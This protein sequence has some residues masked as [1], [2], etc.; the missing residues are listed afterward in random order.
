M[1]VAFPLL[2]S[3]DRLLQQPDHR[4]SGG[5][6]AQGHLLR[7]G[8]SL[9]ERGKGHGRGFPP[10]AQREAGQTRPLHQPQGRRRRL[11]VLAARVEGSNAAFGI[12]KTNRTIK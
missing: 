9:H 4:G 11:P 12:L 8:R 3:S 7:A 5:A 6:A 2:L 1:K 10:R